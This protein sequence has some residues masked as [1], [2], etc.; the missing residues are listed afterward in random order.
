LKAVRRLY[1]N[2][3]FPCYVSYLKICPEDFIKV[4]MYAKKIRPWRYTILEDKN[5]NK[6]DLKEYIIDLM[7]IKGGD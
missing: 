7:P 4:V 1:K 3:G 6:E 2:I 5:L